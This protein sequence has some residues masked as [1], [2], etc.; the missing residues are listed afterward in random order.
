MIIRE[1]GI[2]IAFLGFSSRIHDWKFPSNL[3]SGYSAE[4]NVIR[5]DNGKICAKKVIFMAQIIWLSKCRRLIITWPKARDKTKS[6]G[7]GG[8]KKVIMSFRFKLFKWR[9]NCASVDSSMFVHIPAS[10]HVHACRLVPR[11][12]FPWISLERYGGEIFKIYLQD[13]DWLYV[14]TLPTQHI[15]N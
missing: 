6:A 11:G 2:W 1:I 3:L 9:M 8:R 10:F 5:L 14:C 13:L 12:I 15:C 7:I 4:K